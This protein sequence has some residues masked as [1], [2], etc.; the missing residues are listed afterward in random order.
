MR[1][2]SPS[3]PPAHPFATLRAAQQR[4]LHEL[5]PVER[6]RRLV[7][8]ELSLVVLAPRSK[9][10]PARSSWTSAQVTRTRMPALQ[11]QLEAQLEAH[12]DEA[13]LAIVC[14]PVSGIVAVDLD[15]DSVVEWA[16]T[17]LPKT[18]WRTKTGRGERWFY[19]LPDGWTPPTGPLPYKG[20]LQAAGRY[21]VAPGSIHP[22]TGRAYEALGDWTR[23]KAELPTF[24]N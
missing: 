12:G 6:A 14:G 24:R 8:H 23:A 2:S 19:R 4:P 3:V 20:Q 15:D 13:G 22:D 18:P 11:A 21:V 16:N 1:S 7:A 5:H 17:H 10:P 9:E